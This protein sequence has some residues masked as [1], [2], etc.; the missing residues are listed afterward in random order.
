MAIVTAAFSLPEDA[1]E[2]VD[3]E[4]TSEEELE[5]LVKMVIEV[6]KAANKLVK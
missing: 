3:I 2:P 6:L 5:E 4:I 1:E